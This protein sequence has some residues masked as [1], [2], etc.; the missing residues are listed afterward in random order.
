MVDSNVIHSTKTG[1]ELADMELADIVRRFGPEY[2]SQ[3]GSVMLPS[4]KRA[5]ADIAACCTQELGGRLVRCGDC[6]L[7][8]KIAAKFR[9]ALWKKT[10]GNAP[11]AA[12]AFFKKP[13]S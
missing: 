6:N 12:L 10:L 3:F 11:I 13:A 9:D 7:S 4:Q 8:K 2:T 5:L 1:V